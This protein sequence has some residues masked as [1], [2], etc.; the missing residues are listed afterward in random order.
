MAYPLLFPHRTLGWGLCPS[1]QDPL[2]IVV[3]SADSDAPTTQIWHYRA[4][5]LREPRF[6]I[7]GRLTNEYVVDMFSRELD[8]C[9]NYI[10]SNRER[11]CTQEQD[12]ALMGHEEL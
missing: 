7:F 11:L 9:L 6:S 10:R 3:D 2:S 8:S 1:A 4:W 12:T 5:L